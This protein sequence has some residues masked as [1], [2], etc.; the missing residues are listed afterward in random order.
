[1]YSFTSN[2]LRALDSICRGDDTAKQISA[3][4]G[5]TLKPIYNVLSSLIAKGVVIIEAG[6]PRR[7]KFGNDLHASA[8]RRFLIEKEHP[9]DSIVGSK[10]LILLSIS[11]YPKNNKRIAE[12]TGLKVSSVRRLILQLQYY[13]LI[14]KKRK[15]AVVSPSAR[16]M[17]IFLRDF[18]EGAASMMV[19]Q[20]AKDGVLLWND[21]LH[22]LFSATQLDDPSGIRL[23]GISAMAEYGID[24]YL[25]TVYYYYS[26]QEKELR[27]I[28]IALHTILV[29]PT[30]P[31]ATG[32]AMLL[33]KKAGIEN[34]Q[35]IGEAKYV[36][37]EDRAK[38]IDEFFKGKEIKSSS[39]PSRADVESLFEQYG[40][41]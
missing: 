6:K 33:I 16:S 14:Y 36:G 2:E 15:E 5:L 35:L 4:T 11:N 20:K 22:L 37:L 27:G 34:E 3:S 10:L 41:A 1:M 23:T 38:E 39:F 31:R 30:S 29:E 8:L 21:G 40:M 18:S 32:D 13:G 19:R 26:Y 9:F 25:P 7:Y 12:E 28:D 17:K 24:F